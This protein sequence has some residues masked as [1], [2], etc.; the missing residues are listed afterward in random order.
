MILRLSALALPLILAACASSDK[1]RQDIEVAKKEEKPILVLNLDSFKSNPD[2]VRVAE[3]VEEAEKEMREGKQASVEEEFQETI[4]QM[5]EQ[6]EGGQDKVGV[7]IRFVN[8]L[9]Q[10]ITKTEFYLDTYDEDLEFVMQDQQVEADQD[11]VVQE[12]NES[13]VNDESEAQPSLD[14]D[15]EPQKEQIVLVNEEVIAPE[16]FNKFQFGSFPE[17]S[18]NAE[19]YCV[20]LA[21]VV[22]TTADDESVEYVSGDAR[23]LLSSSQ[24]DRCSKLQL[25]TYE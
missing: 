12:V 15:Q 11:G 8:L 17:Q 19:I 3:R 24:R 13:E 4:A 9:D 5:K 16:M 6:P 7:Y 22:V 10:E 18:D 14:E 23:R 2:L 25:R 21:K 1:S 20:R